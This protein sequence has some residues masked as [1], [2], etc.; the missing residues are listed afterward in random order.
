M[1]IYLSLLSFTALLFFAATGLT[2]N[3]PHWLF[4]TTEQRVETTGQMNVEWLNA[5]DNQTP[6]ESDRDLSRQVQKL[7]VVEH[8]RRQHHLIGAVAEFRVDED[9]CLVSFKGP[10]YAA[11]TFIARAT[12]RYELTESRQGLVAVLNDLHKGRHTGASWS[13]LIDL[14]AILTIL[15]CLTGLVLIFYI[16]RRRT[17]GL[18]TAF[19]GTIALI[20]AAL[21]LVP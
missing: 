11:D 3:H 10:G 21:W 2:L 13:V 15:V 9:D 14:T 1:H 19:I 16:K 5:P 12:G 17:S 20:A 18:L 7:E 6:D 4:G 8:L